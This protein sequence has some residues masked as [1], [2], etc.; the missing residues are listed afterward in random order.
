MPAKLD[1]TMG[2][3][4]KIGIIASEFPPIIGGMQNVAFQLAE[5]FRNY[6]HDVHLFTREN[7]THIANLTMYNFLTGNLLE[8]LPNLRKFAMDVWI[9]INFSYCTLSRYKRNV[10]ICVHG[11]D[12]LKPW[13]RYKFNFFNRHFLWRFQERLELT[14]FR[15]ISWFDLKRVN[16]IFP[17]SQFTKQRFLNLFPHLAGKVK[18]IT[19]G[20]DDFFFSKPARKK[21]VET[22]NL[23]SV[24]RLRH[25]RKNIETIINALSE[26]RNLHSFKYYVIGDGQLKSELENLVKEKEMEE[27][28][29]ILGTVS[30]KQLLDYYHNS[31]LFVLIPKTELAD[32]EGFGI[33]YLEAN[34]SGV[35][36]LASRG[37]GSADAVK[38]GISGYFVDYPGVNECKQAIKDFFVGK[39]VFDQT[40]VIRHARTF[41]WKDIAKKFLDEFQ[42]QNSGSS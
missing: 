41:L 23:L 40:A 13:V 20:V 11:N 14:I 35:P 36:V 16:G 34:A 33:V 24:C 25:R 39:V 29:F 15:L 19:P 18:V 7:A 32:V 26:L 28:V 5:N 9:A 8:D 12:F 17:N 22:F 38:N 21:N 6:G 3:K 10:F 27:N 30:K 4:M 2:E 37:N 31:H 42:H 1:A